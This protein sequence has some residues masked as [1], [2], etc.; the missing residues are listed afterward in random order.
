MPSSRELV[1]KYAREPAILEECYAPSGAS[2]SWPTPIPEDTA[3]RIYAVIQKDRGAY[4]IQAREIAF[5]IFNEYNV[6]QRDRT[7]QLSSIYNWVISWRVNPLACNRHFVN[8]PH[9]IE[10]ISHLPQILWTMNEYGVIGDCDDHIILMTQLILAAGI[11]SRLVLAGKTD[12]GFI[13]VYPKAELASGGLDGDGQWISMDPTPDH[14]G[15]QHR[16]G[17]WEFDWD[18]PFYREWD[19]EIP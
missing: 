3:E 16:F 9:C 19:F 8:D 14:G 6:A 2:E 11:P 10:L 7:G 17:D 4:A 5:A 1:A 18:A 15:R 12:Y 13:H